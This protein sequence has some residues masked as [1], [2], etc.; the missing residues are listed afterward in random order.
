M[1]L[2]MGD[3]VQCCMAMNSPLY[4]HQMLTHL[5]DDAIQIVEVIDDETGLPIGLSW[6]YLAVDSKGRRYLVADKLEINDGY[7][8]DSDIVRSSL[9]DYNKEYA[10]DV[11]AGL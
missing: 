9:L 3:F 11:G 6:S 7:M 10:R 8:G 1:T 4:P 2:F 5:I